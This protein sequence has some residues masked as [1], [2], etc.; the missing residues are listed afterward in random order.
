MATIFV[1]GSTGFL[2]SHFL[3]NFVGTHFD[4]AYVLIRGATDEVRRA[5]LITAL[6][7]A[8]ESY[9]VPPN[10]D[11]LL[12]RVTIVAGD[13]AVANFGVSDAAMAALAAAKID[14]FWHYAASLNYEEH[15]REMIKSTNIDG[16]L[17][18]AN[19]CKA[20]HIAQFA[21]VSTAYTCGK[22]NGP[23]PEALHPEDSTIFANYYEESKC[24]AEHAL[25]QACRANGT[26]LTIFRPS[27]VIGNSQTKNPGGSDTALY[28]FMREVRRLKGVLG[29]VQDTIRVFGMPEGEVNFIPVDQ[30]MI[31]IGLVLNK[32]L[33]DGEIYHLS[34]DFCPP[35]ERSFAMICEQLGMENLKLV[36]RDDAQPPSK[37][38][39]VLDDKLSFYANYINSHKQ[40]ERK[41]A[42]SHG[43]TEAEFWTYVAEGVRHLPADDNTA[44]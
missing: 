21:Y 24:N 43:L 40:F 23:V 15:R 37:V 22:G 16:A 1:T 9:A 39:R 20:A 26:L 18:A 34:S 8:A 12:D 27:M 2:G 36:R 42:R 41:I 25:V 11:A 5:K 33:V 44:H 3:I 28:G 17:F 6:R 31:D 32:G 29:G 7:Q 14:Q 13:I 19:F 38:E 10:L 30:L 4:R 35:T